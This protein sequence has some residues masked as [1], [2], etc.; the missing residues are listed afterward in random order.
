MKPHRIDLRREFENETGIEIYTVTGR[1]TRK[2]T[3]RRP[4]PNYRTTEFIRFG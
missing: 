1:N 4:P 3:D 2:Y